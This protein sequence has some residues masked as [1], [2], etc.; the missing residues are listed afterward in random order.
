MALP[1]LP[2]V[3][4]RVALA[5]PASGDEVV[6]V[7]DGVDGVEG[8]DLL[9]REPVHVDGTAAGLQPLE[10]HVLI[11]WTTPGGRHQL[12]ASAA[13]RVPGRVPLWRLVTVGGTSTTQLRRFARAGDALPATVLRGTCRWPAVIADIGEGGA[14]CVIVETQDLCAG[15]DVLLRAD[16]DGK[17][18]ELAAHVLEVTPLD[19]VRSQLRLQFGEIGRD[20]DVVRRRVL[21]QQRRARVVVS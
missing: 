11:S 8:T 19:E 5:L 10:Q 9:V 7:V 20:A 15:D 3:G 17:D 4:Q 21:A 16:V 1:L 14:R 13:A 6:S 18:L 2:R 12:A